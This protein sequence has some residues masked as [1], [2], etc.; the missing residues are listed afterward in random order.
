MYEHVGEQVQV[1]H[2]IYGAHTPAIL[3]ILSF[4]IHA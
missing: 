4:S 2:A 3:N 1:L